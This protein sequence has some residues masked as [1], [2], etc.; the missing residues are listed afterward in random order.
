M[1][2]PVDEATPSTDPVAQKRALLKRKLALAAQSKFPLSQGQQ[3]LWFLHE[4]QPQA[5]AY[6]IAFAVR[7]GQHLNV[8]KLQQAFQTLMQRHASLRTTFAATDGQPHQVV[9]GHAEFELHHIDAAGWSEA[10]LHEQVVQA[11]RQPFDLQAGPLLRGHVFQTDTEHSVLLLSAH[12]IIGDGW[13][14]WIILD[15]WRQLYESGVDTPLPPVTARYTD[16]I[17][18]QTNM[19][20][21]PRGELLRAYWCE[22]LAGELPPLSLL[23]DHPRPAAL[24]YR[25]AAH[26]FKLTPALTHVVKAF[27]KQEGVTLYTLLLAVFQVLLHRY[28][29]Q[30]K[31]LVG[32]PMAGRT[33]SAHTSVVGYFVNPVVLVS[34]TDGSHSF[35]DFLEQTRAQVLGALAHQDFPFPLLVDVLRVARDTSRNP[36]FQAAFILQK[37]QQSDDFI[38][39]MAS[40]NGGQSVEWKNLSLQPYEL[41]Q[42][43]GQ[44]DLTL[45]MADA[46]ASFVGALKYSTDLFEAITMERMVGHF[47]ALLE[48][49]LNQASAP[50]GHLPL[51]PAL[52]RQQLLFDWNATQRDYPRDA[53]IHELFEAQVE[54]TPDAVALVHDQ[55]RLT[56][57]ELNDRANQLAHHLAESGVGPGDVVGVCLQRT[58][59]LISSLLAVLKTGAAYV[60]LDP[61]YPAERLAFMLND[62]QAVRVL[63]DAASRDLVRH[64]EVPITWCDNAPEWA[65]QPTHNL[66]LRARPSD[67]AYLIYTS[68]STGQ[69]KGV[70]IEHRSTAVLLHWARETFTAAQRAGML[71][72]TSVCFDLSVFEIFVPLAWGGR[73]LLV[74][75]VLQLPQLM[76]TLLDKAE[77]SFINT[78][79]S[80]MEQLVR[81]GQVPASVQV[82][83]LAGE[84]L[85]NALAQSVYRAGV[86]SVFNL[87]GPSEDTTYSTFTRVEEGRDAPITIGRPVA[88]TRL[89][90]LDTQ[91]QP[92]PIGVAGELYIGGE[93]LARGYFNR[94][95]LT[96]AS[97]VP[98]PFVPG[99]KM[100]KTG[101]LVRWRSDGQVVYLGRIDHQ[102][103]LRGYRIEL[104]EIEAQLRR[105]AGVQDAAVLVREDARGDKRLVAY[106]CTNDAAQALDVARLKVQLTKHLPNHM[107]PSAYVAL[108][109]MPLTPNGKLDRPA[110]PAPDASAVVSATQ[111]VAPSTPMEERVATVWRD[112][113]GLDKVG[114]HDNFF[115]LGGH[116]LLLLQAHTRLSALAA[117]HHSALTLVDMFTHSTI[118][119]LAAHLTLS[120]LQTTEH[121]PMTLEK[122]QTQAARQKQSFKRPK[123]P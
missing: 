46:G 24:S 67:L 54:R 114:I 1:T 74:D 25:G 3:S 33:E 70:A 58:P 47:L 119:A 45:E 43:E 73:I 10:D 29:H 90:I 69:P 55:Q 96:A 23:T 86:G 65:T 61:A 92:V 59:A 89:Y 112:L 17:A 60:P 77:L 97:F 13:S 107:V 94:P 88:N 36:V 82:V 34:S 108:E 115:D 52:E 35:K 11:Y 100:Y 15:E 103:K 84:P 30:N 99:T 50:V 81:L 98:D 78:V 8:G 111:F 106:Y 102:V 63:S 14:L 113:L 85:P 22:Q 27:A 93:G 12:H 9:H 120:T 62:A 37:S 18:H 91:L 56:Y 64:A 116:S 105:C 95:E 117:E 76:N 104:G 68:G 20:D 75:N 40:A 2:H 42:Q 38:R 19:L 87:Y 53:C 79:P 41:A 101:D 16:F 4:M 66:G 6:N 21:G 80:A 49:A 110:L 72:S 122:I 83:G 39:L 31:V 109:A 51:M 44:F 71:A 123:K 57:R 118:Q 32:S 26:N 7:I 5:W 121:A 48:A 28:T